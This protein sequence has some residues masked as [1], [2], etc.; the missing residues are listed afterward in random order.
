MLNFHFYLFWQRQTTWQYFNSIISWTRW[1]P[2]FGH[3][4]PAPG[5]GLGPSRGRDFAE[6]GVGT[7]LGQKCGVFAGAE[8]TVDP[9][10]PVSDFTYF[11]YLY[12]FLIQ[13]QHHFTTLELLTEVFSLS[14]ISV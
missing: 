6:T 4:Q 5:L 9:Y 2:G 12:E 3:F 11:Y 1:K 13:N 10:S 14:L 8:A 7:K